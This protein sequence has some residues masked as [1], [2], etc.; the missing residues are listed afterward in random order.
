MLK[1][2]GGGVKTIEETLV[3]LTALRKIYDE[4]TY[5]LLRAN[6]QESLNE[7]ESL[8]LSALNIKRKEVQNIIDVINGDL[9][10]RGWNDN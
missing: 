5:E 1:R 8:N 10:F 9:I 2:F 6:I 7:E 3:F 4:Q